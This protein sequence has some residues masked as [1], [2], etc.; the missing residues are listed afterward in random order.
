MLS[1]INKK[2]PELKDRILSPFMVDVDPNYISLLGLLAAVLSGVLFFYGYYVAG[3]LL[4]AVN[5]FLDILDGNLARNRK[6]KHEL[7]PKGDLIDHTIDRLS[8]QAI[9]IGIAL[10]E[11]VPLMLGLFTAVSVLLVS[12]LGT[13]AQALMDERLYAGVLGRSDRMMI[14]FVAGLSMYF[15][16]EALYYGFLIVF[17]LSLITFIQRFLGIY[18]NID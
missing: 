2:Y 7:T 3:S 5:G 10:S 11:V 14:I 12:Y 9:I 17:G 6:A 15:F 13:Q 16:P 18:R 1:E 8:D 4:I